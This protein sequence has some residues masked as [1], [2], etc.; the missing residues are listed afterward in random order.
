MA[1]T[2]PPIP[3]IE[4]P[5][6]EIDINIRGVLFQL[7]S[8]SSF[9]TGMSCSGHK[10]GN[11]H[12][13]GYILGKR[14]GAEEHYALLITQIQAKTADYDT[15]APTSFKI[16]SLGFG[17]GYVPGNEVFSIRLY[18]GKETEL[19]TPSGDLIDLY[20]QTDD[21][22]ELTRR[23]KAMKKSWKNLEGI[24]KLLRRQI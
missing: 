17:R 16:E 22:Q 5:T 10:E 19:I 9:K 6:E 18:P 1:Y 12:S 23:E 20:Y 14:D 11:T 4:V 15:K 2:P 13:H 8:F 3:K 21:P 24:L 7:N